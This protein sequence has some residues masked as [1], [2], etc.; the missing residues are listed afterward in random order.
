MRER[1]LR[2]RSASSRHLCDGLAQNRNHR[3]PFLL[4]AEQ[5]PEKKE[6][7]GIIRAGAMGVLQRCLRR[8]QFSGVQLDQ[9]EVV[10]T[11]IVPSSLSQLEPKL[12]AGELEILLPADGEVGHSQ[13]S[14]SVGVRWIELQRLLESF[15]SLV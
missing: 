14:M 12:L 10:K 11:G 4:L 2:G 7:T 5:P 13:V 1:G 9:A 15:Y 6:R 8:F 3:G